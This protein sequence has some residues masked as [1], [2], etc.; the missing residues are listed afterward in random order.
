MSLL[1]ELEGF[2]V[3]K[4]QE[5]KAQ[6]WMTFLRQNQTQ[7]SATLVAE[8]LLLEQI[9][10]LQLDDRLYLCW[11]SHQDGIGLPVSE[12]S[13]PIDQQHVKYWQE[14]IDEQMPALKFKLENTFQ[15]PEK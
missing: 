9:F 3:K 15:V 13:N 14:C 8:K 5:A 4:G 1:I 10:S 12:S 2:P 11:Y 7:V 6:E